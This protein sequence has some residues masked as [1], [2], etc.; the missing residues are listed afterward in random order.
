MAAAFVAPSGKNLP[1]KSPVS[2]S[3]DT[4]NSIR[5]GAG[6]R[7][8]VDGCGTDPTATGY[9]FGHG[10]EVLLAKQDG[11]VTGAGGKIETRVPAGGRV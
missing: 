3:I 11:R 9:D 2:A 10:G 7:D 6:N 5:P 4:F 1:E 8:G